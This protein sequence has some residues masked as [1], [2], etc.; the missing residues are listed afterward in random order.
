[1]VFLYIFIL[2]FSCVSGFLFEGKQQSSISTTYSPLSDDHFDMLL[3]LLVE[4][5][6]IQKEQHQMIKQLQQEI[7]TT[8]LEVTKAIH[9][10]NKTSCN[11]TRYDDVWNFTKS[12]E[13][14]IDTLNVS[15]IRQINTMEEYS[16]K[17]KILEHEIAASNHM[18]SSINLQSL[19]NVLNTTKH[20]EPWIQETNYKLAAIENDADARKNDFIALFNKADLTENKMENMSQ[21]LEQKWNDLNNRGKCHFIFMKAGYGF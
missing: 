11:A 16:N 6:Q 5:R 14:K 20:L 8:K 21:D 2:L 19:S 13:T 4:Q 9:D 12:V 10:L 3:K 1:M 17:I 18:Q 7:F 15:Q